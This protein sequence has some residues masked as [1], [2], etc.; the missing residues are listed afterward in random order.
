VLPK[1]VS[2]LLLTIYIKK[3]RKQE[4]SYQSSVISYQNFGRE[5]PTQKFIYG[6]IFLENILG[7]TSGEPNSQALFTAEEKR[8]GEKKISENG[9]VGFKISDF[10]TFVFVWKEDIRKQITRQADL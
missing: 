2:L 10:G 5:R 6:W 4:T 3:T 9:A 7:L 8:A 1:S